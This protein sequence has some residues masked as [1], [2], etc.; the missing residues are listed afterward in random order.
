MNVFVIPSWYPSESNPIY[1]TFVQEQFQMLARLNP[2]DNFGISTWGQG[3][4][5]YL[6]WS[7]QPIQ[8][9]AK[10]I[11][12][13]REKSKVVIGNH[14]TYFAPAFSW[15]R[16]ILSGNIRGIIRAN[17]VNYE[18]FEDD[19]G[20]PDVLH[21]QASYPAAIV[22][23]Y[24]SKKHNIPYV[25]TIRMS[26]FPFNEFL[27]TGKLDRFADPLNEANLLIATS[28]SLKETLYDYGF[29]NTEVI[30][31]PVDTDLFKIQE[32]QSVSETKT[33]LAVGR[34]VKQK[35]FDILI[36]ALNSVNSN[37]R[38][39]IVGE[40]AERNKLE[41][42]ASEKNVIDRIS[43]LGVLDR[44]QVAREM[45]NADLY[46]LSSRH[47]T[48]GNVLLEAM[49]CGKPVVAT[50]CGGPIDIL[51][52]QTGVLCKVEDLQDLANAIDRVLVGSWDKNTIRKHVLDCFS[53]E[54][55]S[56]NTMSMYSEVKDAFEK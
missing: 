43:F 55:F 22:A 53:P 35:G 29:S 39:R 51:T 54:V 15:S 50:N 16:K 42:L 8:S 37:V 21:A 10:F 4:D 23:N 30:H 34:L 27:K 1:G 28:N 31:N 18:Q 20:K 26:P 47:E 44:K 56:K 2:K 17:E 41:K 40:G 24:L 33:I 36:E 9:L 38:L 6:L 14:A 7:G 52:N 12:S 13:D 25:V 32:K 5:P 49:V 48:F 46:V 19:F 3:H 45:Q 11:T